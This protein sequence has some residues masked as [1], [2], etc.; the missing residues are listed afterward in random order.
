MF[1]FCVI[2]A[3]VSL[4]PD[5]ILPISVLAGGVAL[6][7]IICV[8]IYTLFKVDIVLCFRRAFPV[9]YTNT[10]RK[11]KCVWFKYSHS[12]YVSLLEANVTLHPQCYNV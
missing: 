9:F 6:L 10:G 7:F 8:I 1:G 2:F 3:F 11:C 4:D 5:I 12:D